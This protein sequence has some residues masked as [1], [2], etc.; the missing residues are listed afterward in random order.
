MAI[1]WA[2]SFDYYG[3]SEAAMLNGLWAQVDS[4]WDLT[5]ARFRT[6]THALMHSPS[7]SGAQQSECRRV[8][9]GAKT[10]V[11]LAFASFLTELPSSND[12]FGIEFRDTAN[13]KNLSIVIQSTGIIT[14]KRGSIQ[15]G[16]DV[17]ST[18]VPAV[19]A[20]AWNHIEIKAVAGNSTAGAVEVRVNEVTVL[21]LTGID[22]VATSNV[23]FSQVAWGEFSS[24]SSSLNWYLDDIFAWDTATVGTNDV[25]DFIG[26]KKVFTAFP[27]S[28]TAEADFL[29]STGTV[30]YQLIDEATPD[31]ADYIY[32][33][34]DTN[35]SEFGLTDLPGN[36][37][38]VIAVIAVPRLLKTDAGTVFHSADIVTNGDATAAAAIPATTEAT[39]WQFVHT[40]NPDTGVP[41]TPAEF[42]SSLLR[43][44]RATPP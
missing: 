29:K 40:K 2:E 10:T 6:G 16:T 18:A 31:D 24:S 25:V 17:G 1:L 19:V 15:A 44:T 21:N 11:G 39:Y 4:E 34:T 14:A 12:Q 38:E 3:A 27:T 8:F 26:D 9:G 28:D 30:G 32:S 37:A 23:E 22:T 41:W 13:G 43:I 20:N 7:G 33:A 5:T 36:A 42:N 35:V